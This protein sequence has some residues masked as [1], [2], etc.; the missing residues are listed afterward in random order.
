MKEPERRRSFHRKPLTILKS[1]EFGT[2]FS[3]GTFAE[4]SSI[5]GA[6]GFACFL[7]K[8]PNGFLFSRFLLYPTV[9]EKAVPS[10]KTGHERLTHGPI[11]RC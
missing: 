3:A 11:E 4:I 7:Q 8:L 9:N 6:L 10:K 5:R 1:Q 2:D